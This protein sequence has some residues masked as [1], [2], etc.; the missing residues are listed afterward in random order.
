MLAIAW[1]L[2]I[3]DRILNTV[4]LKLRIYGA[5]WHRSNKKMCMTIQWFSP[6][7]ITLNQHLLF[8]FFFFQSISIEPTFAFTTDRYLPCNYLWSLKWAFQSIKFSGHNYINV[9]SPLNCR[10]KLLHYLLVDWFMRKTSK[11]SF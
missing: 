5:H 7:T 9:I 1:V 6:W 2:Y 11:K 4:P 3:G 8:S 10:K